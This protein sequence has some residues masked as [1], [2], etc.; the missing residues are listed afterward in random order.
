[1]CRRLP[2]LITS[3]GTATI[4]LI[5]ISLTASGAS[6]SQS[7]V[8]ERDYT[9][10]LGD[11]VSAIA[12]KYHGDVLAYSAIVAA[13]KV[14][15]ECLDMDKEVGTI[16]TGKYADLVILDGDPLADIRILQ[17][18]TRIIQVFKGGTRVK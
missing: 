13:T 12:E 9:V 6:L 11:S 3:I 1:M 17:E 5:G 7:A 2:R 15:A 8:C 4:L 18:E 14:G 10:Q 16:E